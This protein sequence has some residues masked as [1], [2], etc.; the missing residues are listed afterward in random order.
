[1]ALT[2][3]Q[4][5]KIS[6]EVIRTL[7]SRFESF[8][9][10]A[11]GNR[12]APFHEA[13]LN[14]FADKLK[15]NVSDV[16]FFISLASWLHGLNTTLGQ[17]FF[18]NVAHILC[19]GEKREYTS[20][21]LGNLQITQ[22]QQDNITKIITDLS[23]SSKLP[24]LADENALLLQND[25]S[26]RI[27]AADFSADVF[28][29][30]NNSVVAIELKTVKPNSGGMMGEKQK[31]LEGKA[32]LFHL[33]PDKNIYFYFGFPFDPT[34]NSATS[35]DKTR[36]LNS[37]INANK[38]VAHKEIL[39][40]SELWNFLSG[41]ENTM[42]DILHIINTIATTDFW[43]KM[44]LLQDNSKRLTPEYLQQLEDWN[45]FSEKELIENNTTIKSK[46]TTSNLNRIYNKIAFDNDG[47]YNWERYN[48]LIKML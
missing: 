7:V 8:P 19:D 42:E 43:N 13:F 31:I 26:Q 33:F 36:F 11:D 24:N 1:M 45:L 48:E 46:L 2:N 21:K 9:K 18:E 17:A 4:K 38:F 32:S 16:P 20:K 39:I 22:Q 47:K 40:A 29:E 14:A 28:F 27:V 6:I 23:N 44:K 3:E 41:E 5:E 34:A 10:D 30:T 15:N 37:V 35:Y 25:N 12:N